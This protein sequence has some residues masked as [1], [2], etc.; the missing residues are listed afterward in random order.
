MNMKNI[1]TVVLLLF[2]NLFNKVTTVERW[3]RWITGG[4]FIAA[5]TYYSF[6]YIFRFT[7]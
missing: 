3:V 4:V 7:G 5:G 1:F 2:R 6:V